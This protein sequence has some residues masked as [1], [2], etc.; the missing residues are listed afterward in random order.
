MILFEFGEEP[1]EEERI[2]TEGKSGTI[3]GERWVCHAS[4]RGE[5]TSIPLLGAFGIHKQ[6][7]F[8][9]EWCFGGGRRYYEILITS[10]LSWGRDHLFHKG[11]HDSFA[12][13]PITFA[14]SHRFCNVCYCDFNADEDDGPDDD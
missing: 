8:N 13:G 14:W 12:I 1:L 4:S 10:T 9:D 3:S 11:C 6:V 2:F 7:K 5:A